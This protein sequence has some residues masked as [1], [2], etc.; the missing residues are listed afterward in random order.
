MPSGV[1]YRDKVIGKGAPV[2]SGMRI[3]VHYTGWL[4][5][6]AKADGMPIKGKQF[7][8]SRKKG[9][10]LPIRFGPR[11]AVIVGWKKGLQGMRVGGRRLLVIPSRLGY[12]RRGFGRVIPPNA[13][14]VFDVE[15]VSGR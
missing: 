12:G 15:V 6:G 10:P 13:D 9:V 1:I 8:S 2:R 5:A 14:L 3:K 4:K 7:D 11:A